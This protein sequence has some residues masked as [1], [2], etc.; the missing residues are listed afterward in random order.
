MEIVIRCH[1]CGYVR[2]FKD[3]QE[4]AHAA[5]MKE[6]GFLGSTACDNCQEVGHLHLETLGGVNVESNLGDDLVVIKK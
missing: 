1:K 2:K 5:Q 6:W 3:E 4:L